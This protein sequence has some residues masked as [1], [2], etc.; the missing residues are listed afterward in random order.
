MG[1][2]SSAW[3]WKLLSVEGNDQNASRLQI[4]LYIWKREA[5][6]NG[7]GREK[8]IGRRRLLLLLLLRPT[9]LNI[10][11]L[12]VATGSTHSLKA[13]AKGG[14]GGGC[15]CGVWGGGDPQIWIITLRAFPIGNF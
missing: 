14:G 2:T 8:R 4:T 11:N 3:R 1:S 7:K 9:R 15:G 5:G 6:L 13:K 12:V 10:A